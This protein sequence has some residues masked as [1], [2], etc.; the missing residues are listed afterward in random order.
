MRGLKSALGVQTIEAHHSDAS[1]SGTGSS[2]PCS[3]KQSNSRLTG[4]RHAI[5]I[6]LGVCRAN[7]FAFSLR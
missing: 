4:S 5:G 7:G 3:T 6:E 2:M 1:V